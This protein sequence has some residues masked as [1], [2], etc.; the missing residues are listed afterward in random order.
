M[1][2]NVIFAV[3]CVLISSAAMAQMSATVGHF[4]LTF[5]SV[6]YPGNG[7]SVWNYSIVWDGTPPALSHLTIGLCNQSGLV[8]ASGTAGIGSDGSTGLFGIKWDYDVTPVAGQTYN[9]S[10]TLDQPYAVGPVSY[11]AKAGQFDN[12]GTIYGPSLTCEP[13]NPHI[14]I[15]KSCPGDVFVGDSVAYAI[16]VTNDGNVPLSDVVLVDT[17]LSINQNLG[18]LAPG[19]STVV[20]GSAAAAATGTIQNTASVSGDYFGH[21]V[22]D[23]SGCDTNVHA[24][25]VSKSASTYYERDHDWTVTKS[26]DQDAQI[27]HG[28][29]KPVGYTIDA[30]RSTTDSGHSVSGNITVFNPAPIAAPLASVSDE[31][32][33]GGVIAVNCGVSFPYSL[34]P[35]SSLVCS[36]SSALSNADDRMNTGRAALSNG[37]V[38]QASTPVTFGAPSIETDATLTVADVVGCP[39]DFTCSAAGP[40]NFSDSG[41]VSYEI[42]VTNNAALCDSYFNLTNTATWTDDGAASQSAAATSIYSCRCAE[43]CTLTIG[44]WKTHA[45]FTGR[46][47][48]AVTQYLAQWLGNAF[49]PSS[50]QITT[51]TEAVQALSMSLGTSS[52]GITKLYSQLLAAKLNIARGASGA[53][54]AATIALADAYLATH[55]F[56]AWNSAS[57]ND[58]S[59]ILTWM[60]L[61]DAYNNGVLGP[62]HCD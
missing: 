17:P 45:G 34:A 40:F 16:T 1:K 55:D 59:K 19:E 4:T 13:A 14:K 31:L 18:T 35:N 50:V 2:R 62:G 21:A 29:T 43:G 37:T 53:D 38:F 33:P 49:G 42:S 24:L 58:K 5:D 57:K 20:N 47:A 12:I 44:Y 46:N 56:S 39:A 15:E 26:G 61:L 28:E 36:Y 51:A 52:N 8:S 48:D 6:Q 32:T 7:T 22:S 60:T 11:S 9:V 25:T 3:I 54:V 27:C 30:Q 23:S 10:F 41:S